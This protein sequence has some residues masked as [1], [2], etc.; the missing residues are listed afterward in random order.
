MSSQYSLSRRTHSLFWKEWREKHWILVLLIS[1]MLAIVG[2]G[3]AIWVSEGRV[4]NEHL[5]LLWLWVSYLIASI[6]LGT[7][8]VSRIEFNSR[9]CWLYA[10]PLSRAGIASRKI[11]VLSMIFIP[12]LIAS[13]ALAF[14]LEHPLRFILVASLS[15]FV[16]L[17]SVP[18]C[19]CTSDRRSSL[20][21]YR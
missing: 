15:G 21:L 18:S 3:W 9:R 12:V 7:V 17:F 1:G 10:L 13:V 20:F 8:C 11:A 2:I 16:P 6:F 4:S 14:A 5:L 19:R